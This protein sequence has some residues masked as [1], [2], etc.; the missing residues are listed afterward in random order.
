MEK[1]DKPT[2]RDIKHGLLKLGKLSTSFEVL[3]AA[4]LLLVIFGWAVNP[5]FYFLLAPLLIIYPLLGEAGMLKEPEERTCYI[6]YRSS[7]IALY[8]TLLALSAILISQAIANPDLVDPAYFIVLLIPIVYK[9]LATIAL[10]YST[11]V[12]GLG[13]GYLFT[14]FF[15][16]SFVN[17]T[18]F[19]VGH[20]STNL[21]ITFAGALIATI[22]GHWYPRFTGLVY[23]LFALYILVWNKDRLSSL[24]DQASNLYGMTALDFILQLLLVAVPILIAGL[25]LL[26][27][28][29]KR[30][31]AD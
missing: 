24:L 12:V 21:T 29:R 31:L 14:A 18:F 23:T 30:R 10:T 15:A 17:Y 8:G 25:L 5:F 11:R 16:V 13:I 3:A 20:L 2:A 6:S 19:K 22:A 1:M 4:S 27:T 9:L 26:F 28:A 7:H